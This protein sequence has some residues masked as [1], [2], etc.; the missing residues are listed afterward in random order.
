[1][2]A[3]VLI[4]T[5]DPSQRSGTHHRNSR[6]TSRPDVPVGGNHAGVQKDL[7]LLFHC[8]PRSYRSTPAGHGEVVL[9]PRAEL[10]NLALIHGVLV[11]GGG[12]NGEPNEES[13][14]TPD[15]TSPPL[16]IVMTTTTPD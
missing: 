5:A 16:P 1:M 11:I 12:E 7:T 10:E 6:G 15:P 14:R 4:N 8:L 13:C 3:R 2:K 9:K